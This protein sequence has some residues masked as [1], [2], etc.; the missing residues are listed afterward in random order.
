MCGIFSFLSTSLSRDDYKAIY[1]N[2]FMLG[3]ARGPEY[4]SLT[5]EV[6]GALLVGF[7]R[8]A[9][10]G[11]DEGSHQPLRT[12]GLGLVCNGEIY[13]YRQLRK[14]FDLPTTTH[15]D[16]EVI[17]HLYAKLGFS[18]M[19][20]LLDGVFA[21]NIWDM[22]GTEP[23]LYAARD[24]FGVRPMFEFRTPDG[25][26][27]SSELKMVAGLEK[28][29][30][31][32]AHAEQFA[33]GT[34][35]SF[36]LSQG[37]WEEVSR[38]RWHRL[39]EAEQIHS[40]EQ[41]MDSVRRTL[42]AAVQKRI[43]TS[44]RPI[45][46][47]LS[48]GL[49][50][51][52]ITALVCRLYCPDDPGRLE[53][54]SIGMPGS[55]DLKYARMVADHLGTTHT[56][57]IVSEADFLAAIP[58][59]AGAIESFDTTTVRASVGNY[60]VS[61]YISEHS[62]AKVIFNGDGSD[63]VT[64]GYMYFHCAPTPDAFDAECR[65]LLGDIHFFDVLRSDRTIA[66]Q[67]LEART[68]FLDKEF[69]RTYLTIARTVR[70]HAIHGQCE[71][72]LLRSAFADLGVLPKAVLW[73]TKEAFSDGVSSTKRAWFQVI[74]DTVQDSEI[75]TSPHMRPATAE[76]RHYRALF[77]R[78]YGEHHATTLPYFWMPRFVQATDASARTLDVYKRRQQ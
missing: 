68:P 17:L 74:Q 11:L 61:K 20:S 33:P 14:Q 34:W 47:L 58:D 16:C 46:C 71:K 19:V 8:L 77:Q 30:G 73:R 75:V 78:V 4:H 27:F 22:R 53:T 70:C 32:T 2:A 43:D 72:W 69:V 5:Y 59:V 9:I 38:E 13:N 40:S 25:V 21:L 26:G 62:E 65:R 64:G 6:P 63:E 36:R 48:G 23:I 49:D 18:K 57:V 3:A 15:S 54:Y 60:L 42:I 41:A 35:A 66:S 51:S 55:V 28:V 67:G 56:E 29:L 37:G 50:S 7:H 1:D 45:A 44:D 31:V 52:L 39:P 10:N 24:P 76:Q 12:E